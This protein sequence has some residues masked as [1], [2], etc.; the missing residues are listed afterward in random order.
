MGRILKKE[1]F[2]KSRSPEALKKLL[3][4]NHAENFHEALN[5]LDSKSRSSLKCT[6]AG[7]H[8]SE[9]SSERLFHYMN[10][11][12]SYLPPAM[13]EHISNP[14]I[15]R[16]RIAMKKCEDPDKTVN[17]STQATVDE[18]CAGLARLPAE[19]RYKIEDEFI[20][21]CVAQSYYFPGQ[22]PDANGLHEFQG[23]FF[24]FMRYDVF[25][26]LNI[27]SYDW[28]SLLFWEA[29]YVI[30]P[31]SEGHSMR[32]L[33]RMAKNEQ[34][35][36]QK[37]HISLHTIDYTLDETK[38]AEYRSWDLNRRQ[39]NVDVVRLMKEYDVETA[40]HDRRLNNIWAD[41]LQALAPLNLKSLV[42]D[43]RNARSVDGS[44]MVNGANRVGVYMP[45]FDE[46]KPKELKILAHDDETTSFHLD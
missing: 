24:E 5:A 42:I 17:I 41:K 2:L 16:G 14:S 31:G 45:R 23:E 7:I 28:Y 43:M 26:G 19:L 11:L 39:K 12:G 27:A 30:G 35:R 9:A 10:I 1:K 8:K 20:Q 25:K 13:R 34:N 36:V 15:K 33:R 18:L 40:V 29:C 38:G 32:W 44:Y 46:K 4:P 21:S 22:K 6:L 37:V 3:P